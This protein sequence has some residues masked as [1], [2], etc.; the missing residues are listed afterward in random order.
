M[1][2]F[3]PLPAVKP[4][5]RGVSH[6]ISAFAFPLLGLVLVV[7][8]PS[9]SV[10]WS[11]VVYTIGLTSMYTASATYHRGHWN[12]ITRVRL[13]KLDHAMIMVAIAATYTPISV[14]ALDTR[15]AQILLGIVWRF[16]E[17]EPFLKAA[18]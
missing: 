7:I 18:S 3:E 2:D 9:A 14:A 15:S 17:W 6:H 12:D 1:T 13:R 10:R 4:R 16:K 11:V 8:A 5:L